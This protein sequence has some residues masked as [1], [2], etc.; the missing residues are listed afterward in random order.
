MRLRLP[1][2][3]QMSHVVATT[4]LCVVAATTR[5]TDTLVF[6]LKV[7]AIAFAM[8]FVVAVLGASIGDEDE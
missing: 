1:N 8:C 5:K 7:G 2:G 6:V 3:H 4:V